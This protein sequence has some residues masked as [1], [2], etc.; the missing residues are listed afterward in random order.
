M[1]GNFDRTYMWPL[2]PMLHP[3]WISP[4][5]A[6]IGAMSTNFG[7]L[8]R[9]N[10]WA[11]RGWNAI[12]PHGG[13]FYQ[14]R[15][16]DREPSGVWIAGAPSCSSCP[17]SSQ[18]RW[19][20]L[21]PCR[22]PAR[23]QGARRWPPSCPAGAAEAARPRPRRRHRQ[24]RPGAF[25]CRWDRHLPDRAPLNLPTCTPI[26]PRAR[27]RI[28]AKSTPDR[29]RI[30]PRPHTHG[31]QSDPHIAPSPSAFAH[32]SMQDR[33][34]L[35]PTSTPRSPTNRHRTWRRDASHG[36][37]ATASRLLE[38]PPSSS[39]PDSGGIPEFRESRRFGARRG[40]GVIERAPSRRAMPMGPFFSS[41]RQRCGP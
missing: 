14:R 13:W 9:P 20:R 6:N 41:A 21:R 39:S 2:R 33:P 37:R 28:D 10:L 40:K 24:R 22:A 29:P 4:D 3:N 30:H 35:G 7:G 1:C 27:P 25:R 18:L 36:D 5:W 23:T 12:M 11:T 32:G 26:A 17:P 38:I 31:P 16:F 15:G 34:K 19:R 8:L